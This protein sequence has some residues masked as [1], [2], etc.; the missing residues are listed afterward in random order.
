MGGLQADHLDGSVPA[1]TNAST[2][3][4]EGRVQK[5]EEE[6]KFDEMLRLLSSINDRMGRSEDRLAQSEQ[7]IKA[8][9]SSQVG[10]APIVSSHSDTNDSGQD[11][12]GSR[13]RSL[14]FLVTGVTADGVSPRSENTE[15]S[16]LSA[17]NNPPP[18]IHG[19]ILQHGSNLCSPRMGIGRYKG[20]CL[21]SKRVV[22]LRCHYHR[23]GDWFEYCIVNAASCL[24]GV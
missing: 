2:P 13:A 5:K 1:S 14:D 23:S 22:P 9:I 11:V 10:T 16:L 20:D 21:V 8:I 19:E 17:A 3:I 24:V 12:N 4:S 6:S 7:A 15:R 18:S